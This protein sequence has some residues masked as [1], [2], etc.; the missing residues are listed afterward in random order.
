ME[1]KQVGGRLK[2]KNLRVLLSLQHKELPL[3]YF[4]NALGKSSYSYN[5]G[6]QYHKIG[7]KTLYRKSTFWS[8]IEDSDELDDIHDLVDALFV[9]AKLLKENFLSVKDVA[10]PKLCIWHK[11]DEHSS[12]ENWFG[13]ALTSEYVD[14]LSSINADIDIDVL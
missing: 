8:L 6:D 13:F 2:V 14:F 7:D 11:K 3:S 12:D 10:K 9:R 5:V 1:N 4:E